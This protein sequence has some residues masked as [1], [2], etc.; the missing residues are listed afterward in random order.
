M[1][2][3]KKESFKSK[4]VVAKQEDGTIQITF[5]VPFDEI[6]S[7]REKALK[8]LSE[9]VNVPGFRKGKAPLDKVMEHVQSNELLEHTL[10]HILPH[11]L[12]KA[13]EEN[14]LKPIVYPKYE[15]VNADEDNDWQIRATTCE[16]PKIELGD[17]KKQISDLSKS[18]SIWTPGKGDPTKNENEAK[19]KEEKEQTVLKALLDNNKVVIPSILTEEE[20]NNRLSNLLARIEK[21]GLSLDSY[22]ASVGKTAEKLRE[23]YK[24]QSEEGLAL[25]FI[26]NEIAL[27]EKVEVDKNQIDLS[28]KAASQD[29]N[30]K[31]NVDTPERRRFIEAILKR[32]KA[33]DL[34][35]NL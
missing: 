14:N 17:Y 15:L 12:S 24:K 9:K 20:V 2:K 4:T 13:V 27:K 21:L 23:E 11:L 19:S 6:K 26:L 34:L 28:I 10:S 8:H 3:T 33:L 29:P 18:G 25:D 30:L 5:T 1:V 22:L 35:L 16:A 31:E 32:R 7:E